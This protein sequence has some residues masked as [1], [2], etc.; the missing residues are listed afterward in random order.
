MQKSKQIL[1]ILERSNHVTKDGRDW[2]TLALDPFHDYA[3]QVAGYP[4]ADGSQTVVSCYQYQT[5]VTAPPN[6]VG[7][8]D[9]HIFSNPQQQTSLYHVMSE[10][11]DWSQVKLNAPAVTFNSGLLDIHTNAANQPLSP[12]VPASATFAS[13]TLPAGANATDLSDGNTR[14]LGFGFEVANTT[15]EMYK[16]GSLTAYR[17]PQYTN[18]NQIVWSTNNVG[19]NMTVNGK[20]WRRPPATVGEA[21]LLKGTRTWE[22]KDGCY[23]VGVLN[24]VHNPLVCCATEHQ[25]L[26]PS[27]TS[28]LVAT[29]W[30]SDVLPIATSGAVSA[31][32][33]GLT[34]KAPWDTTGAFL[35]GLS[36]QTVLTVT[37]KVYLERAPACAE[38]N[39]AVLASP[40]AGLDMGA[41]ELYSMA[42]SALPVGVKLAENAA[43]DWWRSVLKVIEKVAGPLGL[44]ANTFIPGASGIGQSVAKFAGSLGGTKPRN[45]SFN[46]GTERQGTRT[47]EAGSSYNNSISRSTIPQKMN[48]SRKK[49]QKEYG[50]TIKN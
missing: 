50:S 12:P 47:I 20:R 33:P 24:S 23:C 29:V 35:L 49:S 41:L 28:G 22:A 31:A 32:A 16:Q 13:A 21:T 7:N 5:T 4:D 11:A 14:I 25:L 36:N 44:L 15:A 38:K 27:S 34:K 10:M 30:S 46:K 3:H 42:I 45:D 48:N 17:M 39:L 6:V 18:N 1:E 43:G 26:S 8:W 19:N 9:A 37:L 2:L 40:S